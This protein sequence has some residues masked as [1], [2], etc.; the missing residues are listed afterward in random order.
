MRLSDYRARIRDIADEYGADT[1]FWSDT[2]LD[3][4]IN[5]ARR[6]FARRTRKIV[7]TETVAL[8]EGQR[9]YNFPSNVIDIS[10]ITH[11]NEP[12]AFAGEHMLNDIDS[13]WRANTGGTPAYWYKRGKQ[14]IIDPPPDSDAISNDANLTLTCVKYPDDLSGTADDSDIPEEYQDVI[15]LMACWKALLRDK[16]YEA[17]D[18]IQRSYVIL[19]KEIAGEDIIRYE[20][21]LRWI[22]SSRYYPQDRYEMN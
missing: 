20:P 22:P 2:M 8:V 15:A 3:R 14:L 5:D 12:L 10:E 6:E 18:R 16:E 1:S 21:S 19:L 7:G 9:V 13:D 11:N 4:F 17:A